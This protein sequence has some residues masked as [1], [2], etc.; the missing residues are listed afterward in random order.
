MVEPVGVGD[1]VRVGDDTMSEVVSIVA[2]V[3]LG[4]NS[5]MVRISVLL[6]M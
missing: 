5:V 4:N 1:Y 3:I 6:L 2:D